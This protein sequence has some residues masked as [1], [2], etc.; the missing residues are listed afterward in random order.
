M[1]IAT[2]IHKFLDFNVLTLEMASVPL[3]DLLIFLLVDNENPTSSKK[4]NSSS[5]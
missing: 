4:K 3:N 2:N 5:K 1:H